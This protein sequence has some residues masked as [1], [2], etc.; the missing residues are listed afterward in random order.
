[1]HHWFGGMDAH[2]WRAIS[3]AAVLSEGERRILGGPVRRELQLL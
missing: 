2:G 3:L 1:M